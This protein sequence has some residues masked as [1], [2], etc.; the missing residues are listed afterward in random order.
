LSI[1]ARVSL[2]SA[3]CAWA[4]AAAA[5]PLRFSIPEGRL[6]NEFFR[7]GPVAAHL[8]LRS[9]PAARLLVAFPAGNSGTALWLDAASEFSWGPVRNLDAVERPATG[10]GVLRGISAEIAATGGPVSLRRTLLG[11]VRTLR[12]F[13]HSGRVPA[14]VETAPERAGRTLAWERRRLDGH[15]GYY[16]AIELLDGSFSGGGELPLVLSPVRGGALRLRITALTGET[17]LVPLGQGELV[18][19]SASDPQLRQVLEFLSYE[20]KLLAGSWRFDTYFGRDTLMSLLLLAPVLRPGLAEAGLQAV[21]DR[22]SPAGEVAH[23][24]DI[25]EFAILRRI[26]VHEPPD[27]APFYDYRMIDDDFMLAVAAASYLLDT[28]GER[29]RAVEFLARGQDSARSN[30]S[31]LARNL[32]FVVASAAP[33]ARDPGWRHLVAL[34]HGETAG[35][36]R[37]SEA[38]LGGGRYPYDVNGVLVPAAL[39]AVTRLANSG[40]LDPFLD[41]A[42]AADLRQAG[43]MAAVWRR[44]APPL[45]DFRVAHAT[46]R[47]AIG[48]YSTVAGV[49]PGPAMRALGCDGLRFRALAL[50]AGGQAVPI[51]NSDEAFALF[52][53]DPD[54]AEVARIASTLTRPFPAGLMTG[55]GLLVSNPAF[56]PAALQP[57]FGR[58]RYHGTVVWSWH[59]ALLRAG[60]DRQLARRDLPQKVRDRLENALAQLRAVMSSSRE[61]RGSELWSWSYAH[62]RYWAQ[63]FG[64]GHADETESNAAQLWSTVQLAWPDG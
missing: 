33:F 1:A 4:L 36:W 12:E 42:T 13:E 24:E 34:K 56:A 29:K 57:A 3:L 61:L 41:E 9:G 51:L 27:A 50:D 11:S 54:P 25:G 23:E 52:L 19:S 14:G 38:G 39:A 17:P 26:A 31:I 35:N 10:G 49:D 16:F 45:Y 30:G 37:D 53:L 63:P 64:Q 48:A 55:A 32:R 22:L 21:L 59:Q 20:D 47:A 40:L 28:V 44:E 60:L 7:E 15:A 43:A 8:V 46:A 2:A 6:R 58:T 5:A 62:G 18:S